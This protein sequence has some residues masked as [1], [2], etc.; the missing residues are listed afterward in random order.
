MNNEVLKI[1]RTVFFQE[2]GLQIHPGPVGSEGKAKV[3]DSGRVGPQNIDILSRKTFR[4]V[5]EGTY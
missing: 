4:R 2:R 1:V 5:R 3:R